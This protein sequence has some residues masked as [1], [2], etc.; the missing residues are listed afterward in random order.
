MGATSIPNLY[1]EGKDDV[2]VINALLFRHGLDTQKGTRHLH[3]KEQESV[4]NLL[5]NMPVAIK[6]A[7]SSPVG[8]AIDIDIEITNRWNAVRG[9]LSEF[10]IAIPTDCPVDGFLGQVPGYPHEFGVWLMPDC[11]SDGQRLEDLVQSLIPASHPLWSHAQASTRA[12]AGLVDEANA[13]L[14]NHARK[15][16]RFGDGVRIKAEVRSW[17]A[18]QH[19]PGVQLGAAINDQILG[20]DSP[21][22]RAFLRW[23]MR[24][25]PL[26][27]AV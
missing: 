11:R 17:L 6:A 18:W 26:A 23:I 16:K 24:L 27:L 2:S 22:A 10:D 3:I 9:R 8:F 20:H 25:Y 5:A 13:L 14:P 4:E 12:A 1:V 21:Q 15:W 7:T 19:K